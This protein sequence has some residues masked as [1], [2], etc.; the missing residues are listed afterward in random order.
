MHTIRLLGS[1]CICETGDETSTRTLPRAR[2]A[3]LAILAVSRSRP[4]ARDRLMAMLW[5]ESDTPRARHQLREALYRLR[6][7]LGEGTITSA[8]DHVQLD[9]SFV[10]CDVWD[11]EDAISTKDWTLA[12]RLYAGPLLDSFF[13]DGAPEFDRW[14][15]TQR[16]RLATMQRAALEALAEEYTSKRDWPRAVTAWRRFAEADPYSAKAAVGFMTAL[17]ASGDR[18]AALHHAAGYEHLLKTDLDAE[19]DAAV[20]ELAERFRFAATQTESTPPESERVESVESSTPATDSS[21]ARPATHV[22]AQRRRW[23][24]AIAAGVVGLLSVAGFV[25]ARWVDARDAVDASRLVVVPFRVTGADSSLGFL[26]EGLVEL[27]STQFI[28]DYGPTAVDAGEVLRTSASSVAG[29]GTTPMAARGIARELRAGHAVYGSVVG[30]ARELTISASLLETSSGAV[31]AGPVLV[32]GPLDSL[33]AL[34]SRISAQL[35]ARHAGA[36]NVEQTSAPVLRAFVRGMADYRRAN[37]IAAG[38]QL[39]RAFELDSSFT[40]AAYRFALI[41]AITAPMTPLGDPPTRDPRFTRLYTL[42]W[43]Q[44]QRLSAEHRRLVEAV[45]DSLYIRWPMQ[46]LPRLESVVNLLPNSIEAWDILG[47]DYYHAGALAGREDWLA[48]ATAAFER[49]T[50]LDSTLALNAATHRPDI[51]F[52]K[53]DVRAYNALAPRAVMRRGLEYRRYQSALMSGNT[54]ELHTARIEYAKAWAG[55]DDEGID[56]ALQGVSIP[57][58][59]L[60]SLLIQLEQVSSTPE[61][62]RVVTDWM[63][64]AS[65]LGG[66]PQRAASL[67]ERRYGADTLSIDLW[68]LSYDA[69]TAERE[70]RVLRA[71]EL[72]REK[73]LHPEA[74]NVALARLRRGDTTGI[75]MI[76]ATEPAMDDKLP[77]SEVVHTVRRGIMAQAAIC[78]QVVRGV[79]ASFS[80]ANDH[81]LLRADSMMRNLQINYGALWNYD[82]AIALARRGY[83]KEAAAAARRRFV[84]RGEVPRLVLSLRDE[85][86]WSA[87]SGDTAHAIEAYRHYLL[88]RDSPEPSLVPQRDSVRRELAQLLK[89][90]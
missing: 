81:L 90:R 79:L 71:V 56:W 63:I 26:R 51:A 68:L 36:E 2:V 85:G 32:S 64:D 42:L 72:H 46:S 41:H 15:E 16:A 84:D 33:P 4:V 80:P 82:A 55:G 66:R 13:L 28:G 45:A 43:K 83:Y 23:H 88:W 62:R 44:R 1:A 48:R 20:A 53:R 59:E 25:R 6:E 50:A 54:R 37:W 7:T 78:G 18:M 38:T 58:R 76:V 49:A 22:P 3:V 35:L 8:G 86:R 77:A 65:L 11:F 19:P 10:R 9:S 30:V 61:Q 73:Q 31:R 29:D 74:C 87:L 47:D 70:S 39:F 21:N 27:L 67:L 69:G 14:L 24:V 57:Q 34:V 60:D 89:A 52:I 40:P 12:D 5:P 17:A 75:A